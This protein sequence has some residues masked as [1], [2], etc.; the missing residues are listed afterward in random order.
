MKILRV[1]PVLAIML[2]A[3]TALPTQ[4]SAQN[5]F[6]YQIS[7]IENL[8]AEIDALGL[9]HGT[10]NSLMKVLQSAKKSYE[11]G[12]EHAA[13][14]K[15]AAFIN[16]VEAK[17]GK[18]IDTSDADI[19]IA[20]AES[21]PDAFNPATDPAVIAF[22]DGLYTLTIPPKVARYLNDFIDVCLA[23]PYGP[24]IMV[25]V[26]DM[27]LSSWYLDVKLNLQ[28][29]FKYAVPIYLDPSLYW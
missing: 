22:Y 27:S 15:L 16:Q 18:K 13:L 19:L 9:H 6:S 26:R 21:I 10:A 14:N 20:S 25:Y 8:M 3:V 29:L 12:N 17:S 23:H 2:C 7:K 5:D 28:N 24:E 1:I 4:T 11:Q